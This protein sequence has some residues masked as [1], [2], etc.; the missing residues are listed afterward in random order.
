MAESLKR[1][2]IGTVVSDKMQKSLVVRIKVVKVH[3]KYKKRYKI[4]RKFVAHNEDDNI[5]VG[6]QVEI[7][8]MKP[9]SKTK[10]WLVTK[11]V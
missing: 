10:R 2:L 8:E 5:K 9:K 4:F 7:T 6:D 11:K 1:K 3:P